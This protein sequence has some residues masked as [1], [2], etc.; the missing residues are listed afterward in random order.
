MFTS[1]DWVLFW[2]GLAC[3]VTYDSVL[4]MVD[5]VEGH[6]RGHDMS[7]MQ[8]FEPVKVVAISS[9]SG[10][11]IRSMKSRAHEATLE[12]KGPLGRQYRGIPQR[13]VEVPEHEIHLV[14]GEA[15][16]LVSFLLLSEAFYKWSTEPRENP[17]M[18][19][20]LQGFG[21]DPVK[22]DDTIVSLGETKPVIR[23]QYME[24]LME[25]PTDGAPFRTPGKN[26]V[27]AFINRKCIVEDAVSSVKEWA[28][29]G[30]F[31]WE[32]PIS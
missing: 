7:V 9:V 12:F 19:M 26:T 17:G 25:N 14:R 16:Q 21:L 23:T 31:E 5:S 11:L 3:R 29:S 20:A 24:V 13:H 28:E 8:I 4:A 22:S 1:A 30:A 6:V 10:V 27:V 2:K 15:R 32:G 18:Q